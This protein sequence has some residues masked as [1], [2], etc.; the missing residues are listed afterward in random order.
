MF[1]QIRE[2]VI[3][4]ISQNG[5]HHKLLKT[6]HFKHLKQLIVSEGKPNQVKDMVDFLLSHNW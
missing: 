6:K 3:T 5:Q 2:T 4:F 1:P